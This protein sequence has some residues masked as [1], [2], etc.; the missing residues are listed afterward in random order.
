MELD[1]DGR[2]GR[3]RE[4]DQVHLDYLYV[5]TCADVNNTFQP[6]YSEPNEG[7]LIRI[8]GV[9]YNSVSSTITDATGT[10]DIFIPSSYPPTPSVF[11]VIGILKQFKAG[12]PAPGPPYT[13]DYEMSPRFPED[14]IGHPG[15]VITVAPQEDSVA[16]T[17]VRIGWQTDV[18]SSS[19]VLFGT[20]ELYTDTVIVADSVKNHSVWLTGLQPATVY[21]YAVG[22][23]DANGTSIVKDFLMSSASPP[24]T[25]GE[26]RVYFNRSIDASVS[27]GETANGNANFTSLFIDRV[28]AARHSIDAALYNLSGSVGASIA[29]ALVAAHDRGV[30][31]RIIGEADNL[32]APF[33]TLMDAGIP[34]ITDVYD[35]STAGTE[36]MHNK[37]AVF[38]YRGGAPESVWVWTGSWN[39]TD[40]GTNNDRQNVIALQDVAL[41]GAYTLEFQEMWGSDTQF[42]NASTTRF[43]ARKLND[44]PH[45]FNIAGTRVQSFFSPSDR[46]TIQIGRAFSRA[47]STICA[48]IY[49]FT[50]KELADS[51]IAQKIRGRKVRVVLDNGTDTGTQYTALQNAGVDVNLKGFSGGLLHHKYAIIDATGPGA[52][53]AWVVTGSHNWSSSAENSN[54][55][56]TLIIQS[57]RVAN[58]YLQEFAARYADAHGS[59]PITLAVQEVPGDVPQEFRLTQNYPNPF[60]PT[61]RIGLD[62]AS[63]GPVTLKVYDL[64]GREIATLVD[65]T[66]AP[67]RYAVAFDAGGLATG[68]YVYRVVAP[69]FTDVRKMMVLR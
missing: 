6:D 52:G 26:I 35:V 28:N 22:S 53:P 65:E 69:G 62:V 21:H 47:Q 4:G 36:L 29:S 67:G 32:N 59:D 30:L 23:A 11:D 42:P 56:N 7:R 54:D 24:Q 27:S 34:V 58:L 61:T 20:T 39:P 25:T 31:V 45:L 44:T 10:A 8:N 41:A 50:R 18:F 15:P 17:A 46:T 51:L 12:T 68:V 14:I 40:P 2:V 38:D 16:A 48:A 55:E 37:F 57:A 49:T 63:A 66:L 33:G 19:M 60:N 9:S 3:D 5:L 1:G 13:A 43:G 64:L